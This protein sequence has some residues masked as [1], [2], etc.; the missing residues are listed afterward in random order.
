M[1]CSDRQTDRQTHRQAD[2]QTHRHT[3]A[4]ESNTS[5]QRCSAAA[6]AVT[7][8]ERRVGGSSTATNLSHVGPPNVADAASLTELRPAMSRSFRGIR[9]SATTAIQLARVVCV[10]D[11]PRRHRGLDEPAYTPPRASWPP[12]VG[13]IRSISHCGTVAAVRRR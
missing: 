1:F 5:A 13:I 11:A 9:T 10:G 3:Y 12:H 6:T 4:T 7:R 2:I 8:V